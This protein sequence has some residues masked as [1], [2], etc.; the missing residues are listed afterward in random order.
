M[1]Q[2]LRSSMLTGI[3]ADLIQDL[4]LKEL[5]AYKPP[6]QKA[7]DAE[8]HVQKFSPPAAPKSPEENNLASDLKAYDDQIVEVE[9]QSSSGETQAVQEDLFEEPEPDD[10]PAHH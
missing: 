1:A 6:Q 10:A 5:K 9:G 2:S 7:S 4:Y 3:S 8:G